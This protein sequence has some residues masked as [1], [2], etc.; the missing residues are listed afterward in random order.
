MDTKQTGPA[1]RNDDYKYLLT[2]TDKLLKFAWILP[3]KDKS[4]KTITEAFEP[5]LS[6]TKT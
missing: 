2:V 6:T 4:W 5:I 1:N 3:L